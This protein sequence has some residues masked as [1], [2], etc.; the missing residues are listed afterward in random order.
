MAAEPL[1]MQRLV[2]D[3]PITLGGGKPWH[4]QL[5]RG[6]IYA[7]AAAKRPLCVMKHC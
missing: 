4:C 2:G 3:D 5:V 7:E 1:G 6:I